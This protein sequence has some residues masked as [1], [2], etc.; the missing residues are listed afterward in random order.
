MDLDPETE[1][2]RVDVPRPVDAEMVTTRVEE[3]SRRGPELIGQPLNL[4][5][6]G[7]LCPLDEV[8]LEIGVGTDDVEEE[9][10]LRSLAVRRR[11]VTSLLHIRPFGSPS[12][13]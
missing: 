4:H 12:R 1:G 7:I 11:P 2:P 6:P 10:D 13:R 8:G 9:A 3:R 5:L